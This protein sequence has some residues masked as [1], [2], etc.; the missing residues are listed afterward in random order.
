VV[1]GNNFP[2]PPRGDLTVGIQI[3]NAD[4]KG[5]NKKR[6]SLVKEENE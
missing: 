1:H 3:P 2:P 5:K 6:K 4:L